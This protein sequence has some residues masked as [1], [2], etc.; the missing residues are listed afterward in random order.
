VLFRSTYPAPGAPALGVRV[1]ALLAEAG[2]ESD[3]D[4]TRNY[5]HGVFVPLK[6]AFPE[7][8]IPILQLSL[9]SDLDAVRHIAIGKALTSLRDDNIL[10]VGSGLSFHNLP[11][12]GDPR[13]KTPSEAFDAWL[14]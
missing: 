14:T 3:E 1:R 6:V 2:I 7:A 12:L 10:I 13:A 9:Q 11:A 4:T 8:D 5:D